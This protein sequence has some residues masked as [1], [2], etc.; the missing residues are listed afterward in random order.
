MKPLYTQEQF[1]NSKS[2]DKLPC[3]CY[4]CNSTFFKPKKEIKCHLNGNPK[5]QI[6]FCSQKCHHLNLT[7]K[8]NLICLECKSEF[9]KTNAEMKKTKNHFCS[10]TCAGLYNSKHRI[11]GTT[12]SKLELWLEN[13]LTIQFPNLYI[14]YN[15]TNAINAE[16]DIYI[17]SLKL[18]FELNG[19]F[20]YEPIFGVDKLNK[21]QSKDQNKYKACIDNTI[22]LCIIDTSEQKYFKP[23]SSQKYLSIITNIIKERLLIT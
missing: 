8:T 5:H 12:R 13:E 22:D 9:L 20:H 21:I 18:A 17:P 14:D 10:L 23:K 4:Q 19:P 15:K 1:D 3:E 11:K 2:T 16:L 6:K 7:K